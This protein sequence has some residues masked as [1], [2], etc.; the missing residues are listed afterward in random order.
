MFRDMLT[1]H[2][3]HLRDRATLGYSSE[4]Q[5]LHTVYSQDTL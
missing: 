1:C 4:G 3:V 5:D 2:T